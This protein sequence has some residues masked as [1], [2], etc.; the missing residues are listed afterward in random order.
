[1]KEN[2]KKYTEYLL[3][4]LWKLKEQEQE[5]KAKYQEQKTPVLRCSHR[6]LATEMSTRCQECC[7]EHN[8]APKRNAQYGLD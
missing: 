1:M 4:D 2:E 5:R 7:S 8:I 3:L 6:G